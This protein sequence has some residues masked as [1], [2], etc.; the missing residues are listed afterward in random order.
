MQTRVEAVSTSRTTPSGHSG[1][2]DSAYWLQRRLSGFGEALVV[3]RRSSTARTMIHYYKS[4]QNT[5]RID[6]TAVNVAT[7]R[8]LLR[9]ILPWVIDRRWAI[10][11]RSRKYRPLI[12]RVEP[13]VLRVFCSCEGWRGRRGRCFQNITDTGVRGLRDRKSYLLPYRSRWTI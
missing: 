2:G 1:R 6:R 13:G 5:D 11:D 10:T 7:C 4:K 8:T 3:V 12:D 9:S